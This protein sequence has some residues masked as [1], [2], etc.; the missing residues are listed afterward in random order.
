[1]Q[2]IAESLDSASGNIILSMTSETRTN[3][4]CWKWKMVKPHKLSSAALKS[5]SEIDVSIVLP[6]EGILSD[7]I[8]INAFDQPVLLLFSQRIS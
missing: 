6:H 8:F 3:T 1:M 4:L 5:N 7:F 2:H